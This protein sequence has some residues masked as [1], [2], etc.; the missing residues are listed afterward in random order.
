MRRFEFEGSKKED[1]AYVEWCLAYCFNEIQNAFDG[2]YANMDGIFKYVIGFW[3]RIN[4][5]G[6]P[7]SDQLGHQIAVSMQV[8]SK[9]RD[10]LTEGIYIPSSPKE[11][12]GRWETVFKKVQLG[13]Q[14][15][16]RLKKAILKGVLPKASISDSLE[17]AKQKGV[18]TA[19]E[20]DLLTEVE[21]L[22]LDA[23]QVDAFTQKQYLG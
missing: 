7:P 10:R 12:L 3:S 8:S 20:F 19:A 14:V 22:R 11:A 17:E 1:R 4:R 2:I 13:E 23:I 21:A 18:I 16:K 9:Q 5:I 6:N 15:V